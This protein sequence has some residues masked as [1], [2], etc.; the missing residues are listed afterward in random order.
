MIKKKYLPSYA[1][2]LSIFSARTSFYYTIYT[3]VLYIFLKE[4]KK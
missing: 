1:S 4:E 3:M 2:K